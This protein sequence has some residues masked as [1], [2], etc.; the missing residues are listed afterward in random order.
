M[1]VSA[2]Q[3][4]HAA[5][6]INIKYYKYGEEMHFTVMVDGLTEMLTAKIENTPDGTQEGL[7]TSRLSASMGASLPLLKSGMPL[8]LWRQ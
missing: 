8:P 7:S 5:M 2:S 4:P 6:T 1:A 3:A